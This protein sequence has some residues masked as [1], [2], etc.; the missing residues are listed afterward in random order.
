[1]S[2]IGRPKSNGINRNI[3]DISEGRY[4][5]C[6]ECGD[7]IA[8]ARLR[9]LPFAVRCK[10]CEEAREIAALRERSLAQ[11]RGSSSLFYDLQG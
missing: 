8:E 7:E 10:D 1:M 11:R 4:G 3:S 9:A 6:F 2:L 5:L